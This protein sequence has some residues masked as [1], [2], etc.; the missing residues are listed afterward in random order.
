MTTAVRAVAVCSLLLLAAVLAVASGHT[1]PAAEGRLAGLGIVLLHGKGGQP[2]GFIAPLAAALAGEGATV[3][4]PVMPWSGSEGRVAAYEMT[5]EQALDRIGGAVEE[6][7]QR[8]IARI[9][10][11]GHSLGGNAAI[12]YAARRGGGIVGV[13]AL[14]AG[15]TPE[16][17]KRGEIVDGLATAKRLVSQGKGGIRVMLPDLNRGRVLTVTATPTAY[18]SYFDPAGPAVIPRNA[19][20]MPA[21]PL[22]WVVGRT[23]PLAALGRSYAYDKAPRHPK[24]LHL[25]IEAGHTDAPTLGREKII[26]WL[27]TL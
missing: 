12:G 19:A 6:L 17:M 2:A 26:A 10:V 22:L 4:T 16:R 24:S 1:A 14:A 23:D 8:G 20:A 27:R 21:L 5:Y 11:G 15:H 3:I 9:V 25:A 13:I 18:V 7:R